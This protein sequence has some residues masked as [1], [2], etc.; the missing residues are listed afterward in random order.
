MSFG[1]GAHP[2][3]AGRFDL[4]SLA[5]VLAH[6]VVVMLVLSAGAEQLLSRQW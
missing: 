6:Q 5:A 2:V 4:D 3:L 1:Y